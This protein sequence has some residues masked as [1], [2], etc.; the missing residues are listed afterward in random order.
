MPQIALGLRLGSRG[1]RWS[2]KKSAIKAFSGTYSIAGTGA[3]LVFGKH[4]SA[5]V[6][7]YLVSGDVTMPY[8]SR[9]AVAGTGSY[10]L[11]GTAAA[12][13]LVPGHRFN[14]L[15]GSYALVGTNAAMTLR[16][17]LVAPIA[18]WVSGPTVAQAIFQLDAPPG[19]MA[20][21]KIWGEAATDAAFTAVFSTT[22]ATIS[23]ADLIDFQIDSF[24][25][26]PFTTGT[27]Y[28]R[29]WISNAAD[30]K[31]SAYSNT[32]SKAVALVFSLAAAAGSYAVTGTSATLTKAA[33]PPN[34]LH[35]YFLG[36]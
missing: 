33:A 35:Y 18:I 28:C 15:P 10:A 2:V 34:K 17:I 30:T 26:T 3:A 8:H 23:A 9:V 12:L 6:G 5:G 7:A 20:T 36:F 16:N 1:T 24:G 11:N 14:V 21:D 19:I 29:F 25:F 4:L 13:S 31:I 27:K 22:S 32:V